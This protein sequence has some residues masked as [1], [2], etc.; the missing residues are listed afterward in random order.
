M[1][2]VVNKYNVCGVLISTQ[3]DRMNDLLFVLRGIEACEIHERNDYQV[4][5]TIEDHL[6][7]SAYDIIEKIKEHDMILSITLVNHFFEEI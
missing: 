3:Q 2:S 5:A 1:N 7:E 4:A 6:D